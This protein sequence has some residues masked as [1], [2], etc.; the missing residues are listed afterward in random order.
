MQYQ[1]IKGRELLLELSKEENLPGTETHL[2]EFFDSYEDLPEYS[3]IFFEACE[4]L[5]TEDCDERNLPL[6]LGLDYIYR[7]RILVDCTNI[8][9][10]DVVD[11]T[12]HTCEENKGPFVSMDPPQDIFHTPSERAIDALL[13]CTIFFPVAN[14]TG[15]SSTKP[16]ILDTGASM[17]ISTDAGDFVEPPRPLLIPIALR[18]MARGM[19]VAGTGIVSWTFTAKDGTE[20]EIR[21]NA[22]YV[23][24]SGS[25]LLSPHRLFCK[26]TGSFGYYSG[27]EDSF[28][29]KINNHCA[30]STPYDLRSG[31]PI[32][33]VYCGTKVEPSVNLTILEDENKNLTAGQKLALEWHYRFGHL[34]F[35]SLQYVFEMFP[36]SRHDLALQRSVNLP[37]VQ[38]AS[39]PKANVGPR[40]QRLK[41]RIWSEMAPSRRIFYVL[42]VGSLLTI[43]NRVFGD[44]RLTPLARQRHTNTLGDVSLSIMHL[45][46]FILNTNW[47][48][49]LLKPFGPN[50][51]TINSV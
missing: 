34:N 24:T 37:S 9:V 13:D 1:G 36:S 12:F 50:R 29:L 39:L 3:E 44:E 41:S 14:S 42:E 17:A 51:H 18:G 38:Y 40:K 35:H 6:E 21:T 23:P 7:T 31:L 27:D 28:E 46:M 19:M 26:R 2:D 33:H 30:V 25:R 15:G 32:A 43:L 45:P 16:V 47:V 20:I 22:Y 5:P 11:H 4:D 8:A 48:S 10:Q 49:R